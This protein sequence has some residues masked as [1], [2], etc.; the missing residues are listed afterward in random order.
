[1]LGLTPRNKPPL[2]GKS[3]I[4]IQPLIQQQAWNSF[5]CPHQNPTSPWS[6]SGDQTRAAGLRVRMRECTCERVCVCMYVFLTSSCSIIHPF[7]AVGNRHRFMACDCAM[8]GFIRTMEGKLTRATKGHFL[9]VFDQH[10]NSSEQGGWRERGFVGRFSLRDH[11]S[12]LV[13]PIFIWLI[14]S[15]PP[16]GPPPCSQLIWNCYKKMRVY[17]FAPMFR[18]LFRCTERWLISDS[19]KRTKTREPGKVGVLGR[20]QHWHGHV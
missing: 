11:G 9:L 10:E 14:L 2:F 1:M 18:A 3:N 12:P 5:T 19:D 7:S 13:F 20:R 15:R 4:M 8:S 16:A 6:S 17:W